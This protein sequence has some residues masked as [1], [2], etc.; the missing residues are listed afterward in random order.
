MSLGGQRRPPRRRFHW[1]EG[2][3]L[4]IFCL[5]GTALISAGRIVRAMVALRRDSGMVALR[6]DS[7]MVALRTDLPMCVPLLAR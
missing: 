3:T 1:I 6:R 4:I 7:G 5:H 2:H